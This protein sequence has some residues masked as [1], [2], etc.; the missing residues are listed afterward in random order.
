[1]MGMFYGASA[2]NQPIG[3][4]NVGNVTNM[5]WMFRD[6]HSFNQDISNWLVIKNPNMEI[7][8]NGNGYTYQKPTVENAMQ[9]YNEKTNLMLVGHRAETE[10]PDDEDSMPIAQ[11]KFF[12][13]RDLLRATNAFLGV[14]RKRKTQ[15][16]KYK[17]I[18]NKSKKKNISR[19][20]KQSKKKGKKTK[21]N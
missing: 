16:R 2:F 10:N 6:A 14:N 7:M 11:G 18:N 9:R 4:W 5:S 1:M 13:N 19:K 3:K 20:R 21:K 17:I 15:K 12:A 8:F